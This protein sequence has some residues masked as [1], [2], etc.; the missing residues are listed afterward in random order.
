[1]RKAL[2]IEAYA[3]TTTGMAGA[4]TLNELCSQFDASNLDAVIGA[5][6]SEGRAVH[7]FISTWDQ[8]PDEQ[9]TQEAFLEHYKDISSAI[10][11]DDY[12]ELM[13]R[14]TWNIRGD[15]LLTNDGLAR[16]CDKVNVVHM[17]GRQSFEYIA[18]DLKISLF[19]DK[20]LKA[21]LKRQGISASQVWAAK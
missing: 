16:E 15:I 7:D 19:D 18:K 6:V 8:H 21:A 4:P 13:I 2:I 9:I 11:E 10:L 3:V 1:M 14:N 17:D 20:L 12:F 5:S